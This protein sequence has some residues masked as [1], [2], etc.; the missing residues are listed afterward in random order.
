MDEPTAALGA[1]ETEHLHE[2]VRSL[3]AA[4]RTVLL[5]SHFLR[6]VLELADTVTVLRDG[7][8]VRTAPAAEET[9]ES[10]IQAMLGRP[11]T[12]AFPPKRP[13]PAT[14]RRCSPCA[15]CTRPASRA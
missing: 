6:E 12:A 9:E 2:I 15:T 8:I 13:A 11:L 10:L 7:R 3:A 1:E 14:R 5:V 4:G